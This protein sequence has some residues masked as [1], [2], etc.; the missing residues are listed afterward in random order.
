MN[1]NQEK[2]ESLLPPP[3]LLERY[4]QISKG[5]SKNLVDLV[6]KEQ[7]HR[8]KL[9]NKYLLHFRIGQFF[10]IIILSYIV[11]SIFDLFKNEK[12]IPAYILTTVFVALILFILGQYRKDRLKAVAKKSDNNLKNNTKRNY[13]RSYSKR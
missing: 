12:T 7:D 9:Q 4:E 2:K 8:H 10:G 1:I 11:Y 5:L 6:K 3:E 13:R